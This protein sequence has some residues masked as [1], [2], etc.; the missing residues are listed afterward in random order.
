MYHGVTKNTYCPSVWTQLPEKIF[1]AQIKWL[2]KTFHPITLTEMI[3][4]VQSKRSLPSNSVLITFDD[5]LK[6]NID[7]VYPILQKYNIPATIFLTVDYIGTDQ[8]CWVDDLYI[9]ILTASENK[10]SLDLSHPKADNLFQQGDTW[11]AYHT[12]VEFLKVLPEDVLYEH[13]GR[14]F[15]QIEID[16]DLYKG[17]FGMLS[18]EDIKKMD[19][20]PLISFGAHTANHRILTHIPSEDLDD[21]LFGARQRMEGKLGH[22][23]TSFCYPNGRLGLDFLPEHMDM[24]ERGGYSCAFATNRG[25]FDLVKDNV[26]SIP[27]VSVGND[28][29]SMLPFYKLNVSGLIELRENK[30]EDLRSIINRL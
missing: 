17:D 2:A 21:E 4:A 27:R 28:F 22:T 12:L 24:L 3:Q 11:A 15:S 23:V 5:G 29:L 8:F 18:W 19:A 9:T 30:S 1:E 20:D 26:F 13:L 6:N 16:R 10:Q 14:I 7:I 25:M